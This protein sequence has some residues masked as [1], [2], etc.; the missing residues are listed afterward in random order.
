MEIAILSYYSGAVSRGVETFVT[1]L[2][3][4]VK[5]PYHLTVYHGPIGQTNGSIGWFTLKILRQLIKQ[6]PDILIAL[7]NNWMS[8]F[9]KIFCW[10]T[11]TKLILAGFAG[12]GRIDKLNLYLQPD[13]F[14]CC[15]QAQAAWA[16]TINS[17]AKI[18]VIPIGVNTDRF[19]PKGKK[20]SLKLLSPIILCVA[21][22]EPYKR[23]SLVIQAVSRLNASLLVVGRQPE[24]INALGKKMLGKRY[25]NL[26]VNYDQLDQIYRSVDLFT[27]P[28]AD[29][30]AYG[31]VILE[32]M[33]S[34]L[35]VVVND[36]P[37]RRELVGKV[38][39][40]VNPINLN[41]YVSALTK[42]LSA[43]QPQLFRDQALKF[44]WA[45]IIQQYE[46]LWSNL[47]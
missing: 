19:Q 6:P 30:E 43:R 16:K 40:L 24:S 12:I 35:A 36:D 7:N 11:P 37:I 8:I 9:V 39:I 13:R 32:A 18:S 38:G 25:Q 23:V 44:S 3:N 29:S 15:T 42:G 14:I 20:Y 22:P 47:G 21:G 26:L 31:V 41:Q 27:L 28:S 34:G 45:D 2:V 46:Q 17:Q 10:F 1:E 33:A 4:R 5:S